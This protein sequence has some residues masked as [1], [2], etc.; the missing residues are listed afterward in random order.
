[1]PKDEGLISRTS[2]LESGGQDEGCEHGK[3][4]FKAINAKFESQ[5]AVHRVDLLGFVNECL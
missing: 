1:M 2:R 5:F 4:S 3:E